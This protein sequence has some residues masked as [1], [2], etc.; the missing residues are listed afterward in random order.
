MKGES[1]KFGLVHLVDSDA[2]PEGGNWEE[3][4]FL[5]VEIE[6]HDFHIKLKLSSLGRLIWRSIE[7][8]RLE[9]EI[10]NSS[11]HK[12]CLKPWA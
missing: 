5:E 1:Y 9:I 3:T 11:G 7:R 8:S 6:S 4:G 10:G 12:C 2:C